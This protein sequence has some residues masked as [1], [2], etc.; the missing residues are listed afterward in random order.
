MT[1]FDEVSG[2]DDIMVRKMIA[3][4]DLEVVLALVSRPGVQAAEVK[5][6]AQ[7]AAGLRESFAPAREAR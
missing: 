7:L 1:W 3:G 4:F 6:L 2:S 5:L